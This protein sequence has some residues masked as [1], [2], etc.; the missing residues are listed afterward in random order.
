MDLSQSSCVPLWEA[1]GQGK[2]VPDELRL[3][4]LSGKSLVGRSRS[5]IGRKTNG[6]HCY[7]HVLV[8]SS[9]SHLDQR[10]GSSTVRV[11]DTTAEGQPR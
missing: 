9:I 5:L 4:F 8:L 1:I 3:M 2:Q 11:R 7:S 6:R 10:R